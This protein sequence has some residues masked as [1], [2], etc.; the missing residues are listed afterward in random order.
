MMLRAGD[1][2]NTSLPTGLVSSESLHGLSVL[3]C[4]ME[5]CR[6]GFHAARNGWCWES[7]WVLPGKAQ[8]GSPGT[9]EP[10]FPSRGEPWC[11]LAS[12]CRRRLKE[13][14]FP[15]SS[16]SIRQLSVCIHGAKPPN[17]PPRH[18][19]AASPAVPRALLKPESHREAGAGD[20]CSSFQ[21]IVPPELLKICRYLSGRHLQ[22]APA[23]NS[24]THGCCPHQWC[25][26]SRLPA[27]GCWGG[28]GGA[29]LAGRH[30]HGQQAGGRCIC[31]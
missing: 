23:V 17:P 14:R 10:R 12:F 9:T 15:P 25:Q 5:H 28:P 3:P 19:A 2:K 31:P 6:G 22:V 21:S 1:E 29:M 24:K 18:Q 4:K 27:R 20:A 8:V 7:S 11:S 13:G 30:Q 26:R 16:S